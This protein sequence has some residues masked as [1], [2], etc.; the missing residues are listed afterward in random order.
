MPPAP[1]ALSSVMA[2][3]L[4][5]TLEKPGAYRLG[6]G[7][8]PEARDIGRAIRLTAVAAALA[9]AVLLAGAALVRTCCSAGT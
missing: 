3:A 1:G 4:G 8:P 2:G 7:R 5:L 9:T 6:D